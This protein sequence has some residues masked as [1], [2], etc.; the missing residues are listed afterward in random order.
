MDKIDFLPDISQYLEQI[1]NSKSVSSKGLEEL[2][3]KINASTGIGAA[4]SSVII[5]L[6]FQEVRNAIL[7]GD[8]VVLGGFGKFFLATPQNTK[9]KKRI[10]PKFKP[11]KKLIK[12]MNHE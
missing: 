5:K 10:F 9:N 2:M 1:D 7:R 12:K 3:Y 11:Y 6:F 4:T 8:L